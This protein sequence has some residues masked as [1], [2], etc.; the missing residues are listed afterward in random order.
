MPA[1]AALGALADDENRNE[2]LD[3]IGRRFPPPPG[4]VRREAVAF[5][6]ARKWSAAS[7]AGHGTWILGAPEI[8][9]ANQP[10]AAIEAEQLAADGRR[11]VALAS[12]SAP[13]T[14]ES[15]P[16]TPRP[17][18]LIVLAEQVRPDAVDTVAY[19]AKQGV[20]LKV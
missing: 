15:L 19:F 14:G 17:A 2:T 7:F 9:F 4:W 20:A 11:V 13:L 16:D 6:S 5:S 3:A 1:E 10:Q 12:S 18:A 8:V